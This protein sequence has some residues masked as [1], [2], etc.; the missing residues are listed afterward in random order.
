[1]FNLFSKPEDNAV[2]AQTG[3]NVLRIDASMRREGSVTRALADR[4]LAALGPAQVTR[5]DLAAEAVPFVD[6][7]WIGANFTKPDQ[8]S[9]AQRKTLARSDALVAELQAA[10]VLVIAAPIY[11]FGPPAALKA[12]IDQVA[13]ARVT[14]RYTENGP[15]GLLKGKKAY[16]LVASGG[17]AAESAIDFATPYLRHALKFI[18]V[19]DVTVVAADGLMG[20]AAKRAVA[21]AAVDREAAQLAA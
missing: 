6:E 7:D 8:R 14:F 9:D 19:E 5:R 3:P 16:L 1:M 20:D 21:E 10:D 15:E 12:W 17:T 18:G 2:A 13:R 11:N 4:F